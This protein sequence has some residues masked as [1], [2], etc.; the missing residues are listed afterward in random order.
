MKRPLEFTPSEIAILIPILD[1][2]ISDAKS[3]IEYSSHDD[4]ETAKLL[5][6]DR[7]RRFRLLQGIRRKLHSK[8]DAL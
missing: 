1:E 3:A 2:A 5:Q 6:D 7:R 8:I 4:E